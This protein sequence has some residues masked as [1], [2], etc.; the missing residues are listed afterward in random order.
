LEEGGAPCRLA[1]DPVFAVAELR[2]L[3]ERRCMVFEL[4]SKRQN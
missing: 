3:S 4:E 1:A 2:C